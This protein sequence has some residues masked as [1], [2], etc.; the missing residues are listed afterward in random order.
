MRERRK[1]WGIVS[2]AGPRVT[3]ERREPGGRSLG[4]WLDRHSVWERPSHPVPT[5]GGR[6][7]VRAQRD[8][9]PA[10]GTLPRL[11]RAEVTG[12]V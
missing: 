4:R 5:A 7:E 9:T 1:R 12:C 2:L 6:G 8:V 3:A 10:E 11:H